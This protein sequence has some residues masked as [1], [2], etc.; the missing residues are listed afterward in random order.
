LQSD[1][2]N[3]GSNVAEFQETFTQLK[4]ATR[5]LYHGL[6]MLL[7]FCVVN[8]VALIKV[9]HK[10]DLVSLFTGGHA[11]F[12]QSIVSASFCSS[13]RL[14]A[15]LELVE[16]DYAVTFMQSA[17]KLD[18]NGN[19]IIDSDEAEDDV[20]LQADAKRE[21]LLSEL[22]MKPSSVSRM[23]VFVIGLVVGMVVAILVVLGIIRFF[24]FFFSFFF[25]FSYCFF[26]Y[27]PLLIAYFS[28]LTFFFQI[29][30]LNFFLSFF[31]FQDFD[32]VGYSR[33]IH[34]HHSAISRCISRFSRVDV[35]CAAGVAMGRNHSD[36]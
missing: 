10:H 36:L 22:H 30:F 29:C 23:V 15:L 7:N 35:V 33:S 28:F 20:P 32:C 16:A 13:N 14:T 26:S 5:A 21:L 19:A 11:S 24:F 27:C 34:H 18:E 8:H 3:I 17:P 4:E 25:L 1:I 31:S 2:A 9:L 6:N 12:E